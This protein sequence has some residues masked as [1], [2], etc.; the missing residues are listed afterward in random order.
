[1]IET[2]TRSKWFVV[3]ASLARLTM[4]STF[5]SRSP[6]PAS[7]IHTKVSPIPSSDCMASWILM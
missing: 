6:L 5:D 2:D 7:F 4:R 3:K 1:M